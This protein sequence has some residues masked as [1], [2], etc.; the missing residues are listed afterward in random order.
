MKKIIKSIV[1]LSIIRFFQYFLIDLRR[2]ISFEKK[3]KTKLPVVVFSNSYADTFFGY[4]DISPFNEHNEVIY[5]ELKRKSNTVSIIVNNIYNTQKREFAQSRAWNW[6]QG[7]RLRWLPMSNDVISFNDFNGSS[8]FNR[9]LNIRTGEER[10]IDWPIYD[11]DSSG[12]HALSLNFERLGSLRPGYGYTCKD[13]HQNETDLLSEGILL[14]DYRDNKLIKRITYEKIISSGIPANDITQCYIN[15]LSFSP[16]GNKFLFFW[17]EIV[18]GYHKAS[19]VVYDI[20]EDKLIPLELNEKVSHYVWVDEKEIL[21]TAYNKNGEC[22]YYRYN[23]EFR[24]RRKEAVDI[25][26]KDGHP[27]MLEHPNII[28]TDTYPDK[29]SYQHIYIVELKNGSKKE[30]ISIYSNPRINGERRT[31]LHPRLNMRK[32][33]ISF[34]SNI[35]YRRNFYIMKLN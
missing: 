3:I 10:I 4:Y 15:H 32:D 6:Q 14:I 11:I 7:V 22:F 19:L 12:N 30:I 24:S 5:L 21:C 9:V 25:L 28:L 33:Y 13:Y 34:D 18:K 26:N 27:S 31:D 1:P 17:I 8:Y 2:F 35:G 23:I 29:R 16:S 20:L